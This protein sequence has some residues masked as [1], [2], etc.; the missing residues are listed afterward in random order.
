MNRRAEDLLPKQKEEKGTVEMESTE[1]E[2]SLTVPKTPAKKNP[3]KYVA[4]IETPFNL[5]IKGYEIKENTETP[6]LFFSTGRESEEMEEEGEWFRKKRLGRKMKP[7]K[8]IKHRAS[9]IT[10]GG[11][12]VCSVENF[13]STH[14]SQKQTLYTSN[15][16]VVYLVEER[17]AGMPFPNGDPFFCPICSLSLKEPGDPT[18]VKISQTKW[19][20]L[21][22][23]RDRVREA[24]FLYRLRKCNYITTI[25]RSWEEKAVLHIEMAYCNQGTLTDNMRGYQGPKKLAQKML[26]ILQMLKGLKAVHRAKIVHLDIKP[27]NI[28]LHKDT[29]DS[30]VV[31]IGDFGISRAAED[32]SE[33]EFDGDRL[34]MAP[35]LLQNT[36]SYASDVYSMGLVLIEFL[37]EIGAP[38]KTIPWNMIPLE[39]KTQIVANSGVPVFIYDTIKH[40]ISIDPLSRPTASEVL[41][42]FRCYKPLQNSPRASLENL[43]SA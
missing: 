22:E 18:V 21:K 7:F 4:N 24:R 1:E 42:K 17:Q 3:V 37:F 23:K 13:F 28:Y 8:L 33:I 39:E 38:L 12:K 40:M 16:S 32:L 41:Q 6:A 31:K 2:N 19:V 29:K 34:Y 15:Q 36:C 25:L 43:P 10:K 11:V 35:E 26:L 27:D 20:T 30:L 5:K 9:V 14:Y